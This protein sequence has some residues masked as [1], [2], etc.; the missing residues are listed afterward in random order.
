M[1]FSLELKRM[2]AWL[3]TEPPNSTIQCC[4]FM[5]LGKKSLSI[6]YIGDAGELIWENVDVKAFGHDGSFYWFSVQLK[7]AQIGPS[8]NIHVLDR[9]WGW[10]PA[11]EVQIGAEDSSMMQQLKAEDFEGCHI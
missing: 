11:Q 10:S 9:G 4:R 7:M 1:P 6:S 5:F 3:L 8:L 2:Q